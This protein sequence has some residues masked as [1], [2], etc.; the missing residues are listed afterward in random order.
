MRIPSQNLTCSWIGQAEGLRIGVWDV[1]HKAL[2]RSSEPEKD[3]QY[4]ITF[5]D[6]F[7]PEPCYCRHG[8]RSSC[9]AEAIHLFR[10]RRPT[11]ILF[12]PLFVESLINREQVEIRLLH[13][14]ART[15]SLQVLKKLF[16]FQTDFIDQIGVD[17]D[18][19]L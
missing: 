10:D 11:H 18:S 6:E 14:A 19:L 2:R 15:E 3:L 9:C 1:G 16:V 4:A 13:L 17:N 5:S 8:D 12:A 7:V